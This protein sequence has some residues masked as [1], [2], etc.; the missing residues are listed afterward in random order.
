VQRQHLGGEEVG[1]CQQR[2]VGPNEVA[3]VVVRLRSCAGGKLWRR[4]TLP[5]V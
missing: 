5:T 4:K 3:Q 1:P 2:Y